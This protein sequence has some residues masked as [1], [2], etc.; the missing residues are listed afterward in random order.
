ME[1]EGNGSVVPCGGKKGGCYDD[2]ASSTLNPI[3]YTRKPI[4][5]HRLPVPPGIGI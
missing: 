4:W 2:G 3:C 5:I 1:F